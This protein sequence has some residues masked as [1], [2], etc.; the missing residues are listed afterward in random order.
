[1]TRGG[2]SRKTVSSFI[3]RGTQICKSLI[4]RSEQAK[5]KSRFDKMGVSV[6]FS[7]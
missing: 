5:P 6:G 2:K 7:N 4:V 1:M 3:L